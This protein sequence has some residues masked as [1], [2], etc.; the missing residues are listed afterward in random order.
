MNFILRKTT[1]VLAALAMLVLSAAIPLSAYADTDGYGEIVFET[2]FENG[3]GVNNKDLQ[4]KSDG[5]ART[6]VEMLSPVDEEEH[7]KIVGV[8]TMGSNGKRDHFLRTSYAKVNGKFESAMLT[9]EALERVQHI[10]LGMDIMMGDYADAG[11][12]I[13]T[14]Q[15]VSSRP[16][17]RLVSFTDKGGLSVL[18]VS[19]GNYE[20]M[21]W[22]RLEAFLDYTKREVQVYI[23]GEPAGSAPMNDNFGF[24]CLSTGVQ[25]NA[26]AAD[27]YVYVDN[28]S[29]R[30]ASAPALLSAYPPD[31]YRNSPIKGGTLEL[32]FDSS[33]DANAFPGVTVQNA[34]GQTVDGVDYEIRGAK[35]ILTVTQKLEP[36]TGYTVQIPAGVTGRNGLVTKDPIRISFHTASGAILLGALAYTEGA[37]HPDGGQAAVRAAL[38]GNSDTKQTASV[39]IAAYDAQGAMLGISETPVTVERGQ[40]V[41]ADSSIS[42]TGAVDHY[43]A[44]VTD[45]NGVPVG[46]KAICLSGDGT[47]RM[48]TMA[49]E[50]SDAELTLF[51]VDENAVRIAGT[52]SK[53]GQQ[54]LIVRIERQGEM[55][56]TAP[57]L[58]DSSGSFA[59]GFAADTAEDGYKLTVTGQMLNQ[60]MTQMF[61]YFKPETKAQI[62]ESVN[63]AASVS[64]VKTA[65]TPYQDKLDIKEGA[66]CQAAF[67]ALYEQKPIASFEEMLKTMNQAFDLLETL[68]QST[69]SDMS[70]LLIAQEA[71]LLKDHA[72]MSC[73]K[74]LSGTERNKVCRYLVKQAPFADFAALRTAFGQAI[75][76]YQDSL[77]TNSDN[78]NNRPGGSGGGG[79][80]RALGGNYIQAVEKDP[81][82]S[83][84][85][86]DTPSETPEQTEISFTDL[87]QAAWAR[88]SI[89]SLAGRGY[90]SGDGDGKFR[91]N[92]AITR[93]EFVKL[94][95][96]GLK[97]DPVS[98]ESGFVDAAKNAWYEP[99]LAAARA[100]GI[101][102]GDD[103]GSF[104]VGQQITRQDMAVMV[105]RAVEAVE[106]Q[107]PEAAQNAG[108]QDYGQIS[109]YAA[110]AVDW[111]YQET[112]ISGMGDQTFAP[113]EN[114]SRA[115]AAK[116]TEGILRWRDGR[117][118]G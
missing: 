116:V 115:Q 10:R 105:F 101:V 60:T 12:S 5:G 42:V 92:D 14:H 48:D 106:G 21:T 66:F 29:Y 31:G 4:W 16:S 30:V 97:I 75:D 110:E 24:Y 2:D 40:T 102:N 111:M 96:C 81:Q 6:P 38:I 112:L 39:V 74:G 19:H 49:S 63:G 54:L 89:L 3:L 35:L 50:C 44:Y 104:G 77:K 88:D 83:D 32:T 33:L 118:H 90:L 80:G 58:S 99:Y 52:L 59:A 17:Y 82:P 53:A 95:L 28:L 61:Y 51:E 64:A 22:Y 23:G 57:I 25:M 62:L 65:L 7:G 94:L 9:G 56:W 46:G 117:N 71:M 93:E 100:A 108:F 103:S 68:N 15:S 73:Y 78:N 36:D 72:D 85:P 107:K 43:C 67:E 84:T 87:D 34:A 45:V 27:T 37:E 18:G 20:L 114:A 41:S 70:G 55:I 47:R 76:D 26:N 98:R 79:G 11:F 91:P 1:A 13:V 109:A 8:P 86:S 113:L 69:W